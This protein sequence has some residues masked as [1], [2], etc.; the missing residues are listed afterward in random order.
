[1]LNEKEWLLK[2]IHHRVKNNLHTINGLLDAQLSYLNTKEARMAISDSQHRVQAMSLLH[3]KLFNSESLSKVQMP[4]YISE[5]IGYLEHAFSVEQKI[6]FD[7]DIDKLEFGIS[8]ALP[9]GLI[10]NEAITNAIKYAFGDEQ[11]GVIHVRL[12]QQPANHFLLH[13]SDTGRGLPED[14]NIKRTQSVGMNLMQGLSEDINGVFAI[15]NNHGTE[16]NISFVYDFSAGEHFPFQQPQK[17][18]L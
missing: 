13:I 16:I 5:L 10:L 12:K 3:Q 4:E 17:S 14:F 8:H 7:A 18:E 11:K 2:E 6:Q 1:M 15:N 9:I